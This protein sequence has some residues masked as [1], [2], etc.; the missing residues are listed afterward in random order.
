[1]EITSSNAKGNVCITEE[2]IASI[3]IN[4]AKD[5]DGI[6]SFSNRPLDVVGKIKKGNLKVMSPVKIVQ[7]G[8]AINLTIYVNL[9]PNKKIQGIA[10]QVQ[11]NVK[12]AIQNMTGRFVSKVNVII[13][14]VDFDESG[15]S[16]VPTET[17]E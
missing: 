1:M 2:A 5:V 14:G 6:S 7:E 3:A 8:D 4:A 15:D 16:N 17:K 9:K 12:E 10:E 11:Q 13:A